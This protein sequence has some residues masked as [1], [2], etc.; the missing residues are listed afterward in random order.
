MDT[1]NQSFPKF[2]CCSDDGTILYADSRL[3]QQEYQAGEVLKNFGESIQ[4]QAGNDV[5]IYNETD[6]LDLCRVNFGCFHGY[7]GIVYNLG[8]HDYVNK[9]LEETNQELEEIFNSSHDG[10]IVADENGLYI[11]VNDSFERITGLKKFEVKGYSADEC[12][13]AGKISESTTLRVLQTGQATTFNQT[14]L[15]SGRQ[16]I[17]TSSPVFDKSGKM[18]RVVSNVRDMTEIN[19]LK[20]ELAESHEKI[21]NYS[22]I[23]KSLT[24]EQMTLESLVFRSPK[25]KAIRDSAIKF[26]KV[27]APLLITGESGVGKEI[28]ADLIHENSPRKGAP[29]LKIN[30][31]AIPETLLE[32]ELFGYESG[33]FTGAK[34]EGFPGLLKLAS[35]GT[36][37]LD[38]I[39]ELPLA[40]QVK[41]LRVISKQEFYRV[42]GK[43][44]IKVDVRFIAVT[45]RDLQEMV[46]QKLFRMDLFYRLNVLK[47]SIPPLRERREDIIPITK[48]FLDKYNKKYHMRKRISGDICRML[49]DYSWKGNVRELENLVERLVIS[50]DCA[51]IPTDYL[52]DEMQSS[53]NVAGRDIV[54]PSHFVEQTYKTAK[55]TFEKEFFRQ[56]IEKYK[57][58]RKTAKQLGVD[59]ST[60]VKK[61]A[62]YGISLLPNL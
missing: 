10:F 52:P 39:S 37:L 16:S 48:Y 22:Q 31:G 18:I 4:C 2:V 57:S 44:L 51:D 55:E 21:N 46:N 1:I 40:L 13:K 25:I 53:L 32:A 54:T 12:I 62:K 38:E 41:L 61:A 33:A 26:A 45:N 36:L 28:I 30:C 8:V 11:H 29:Y 47:I 20:A 49:V 56:A 58:S 17:I 35:G 24:K 43:D 9:T 7:I 27:D 5:R 34:K 3:T 19:A 15:R 60:I 50:S 42:G 6:S 59:H 14:F 23:V